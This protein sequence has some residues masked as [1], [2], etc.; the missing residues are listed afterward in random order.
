MEVKISATREVDEV[1]AV[2]ATGV[3]E[4]RSGADPAPEELI[5]EVD[6]DV[7]EAVAEV[8]HGGRV[9]ESGDRPKAGVDERDRGI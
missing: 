1:P 3:E 4:A 6:V 7:A 5:E 8:I 9:G 2:A